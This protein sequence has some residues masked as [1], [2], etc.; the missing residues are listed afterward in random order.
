MKL[1]FNALIVVPLLVTIGVGTSYPCSITCSSLRDSFRKAKVIF[2]GQ[3]VEIGERTNVSSA[4][5]LYRVRF[6]IEKSWKGVKGTEIVVLTD[7]MGIPDDSRLCPGF[8]FLEGERYLVFIYGD[9]LR[10]FTGPCGGSSKPLTS[11]SNEI[12]KLNSWRFRFTAR[13]FP[14]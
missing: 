1:Y 2:V 6:R 12:K 4:T 10:T 9:D 7:E 11:V 13:V 5:S 14:F 3:V 8:N